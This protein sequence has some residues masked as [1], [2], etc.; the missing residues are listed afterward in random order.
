MKVRSIG[1]GEKKAPVKVKSVAPSPADLEAANQLAKRIA[2]QNGLITGENAHTGGQIPKFYDSRSGRELTSADTTPP[3]GKFSDKVP[4]YVKEL[5]W[6]DKAALPFYID[7]NTGDAQ[8]V[9]KELFH[10]PR[11]NPNRGKPSMLQMIAKR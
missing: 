8:Y 9:A 7:Q 5:Q 4:L 6:D 10:S 11:F 3:V 2:I 1:G